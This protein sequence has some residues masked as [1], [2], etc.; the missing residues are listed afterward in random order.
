MN[1]LE[2]DLVNKIISKFSKPLKEQIIKK[3]KDEW[4]KFKIDFNIVFT[5]YLNKSYEKY[6]KIKTILYKTE[7]QYIYD[8]FECPN[9]LQKPNTHIN[10]QDVNNILDISNFII[11]EGTGG[12]G[13]STL[14]KHLF[15]DEIKKEDLV[16][17]FIELK[18]I[19]LIEGN[20][21]ILD[22]IYQKL[23]NLGSTIKPE[24]MEYALNSGCF[25]F[26]FDGYDEI[27]SDKKDI[28]FKN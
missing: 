14:L 24:Y 20:Y 2:N 12:I 23:N 15:I 21:S 16:P 1:I 10:T 18:D 17:L 11:I 5:N 19:N 6:S 9:L 13:K 4:E 28:F 26:L 22:V 3:S 27:V 8:F 7:P 25:L